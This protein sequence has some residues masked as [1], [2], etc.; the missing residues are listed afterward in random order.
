MS[1]SKKSR[2]GLRGSFRWPK[3]PKKRPNVEIVSLTYICDIRESKVLYKLILSYG[4]IFLNRDLY[5]SRNILAKEKI[6]VLIHF[7]RMIITR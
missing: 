2:S 5:S 1:E 7:R 4:V 6:I 3:K